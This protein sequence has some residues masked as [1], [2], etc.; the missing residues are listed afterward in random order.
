MHWYH[1]RVVR[2]ETWHLWTQ[3]RTPQALPGGAIAS[4]E[5]YKVKGRVLN[6]QN[7]RQSRRIAGLKGTFTLSLLIWRQNGCMNGIYKHFWVY[8]CLKQWPALPSAGVATV[9]ANVSLGIWVAYVYKRVYAHVKQGIDNMTWVTSFF[10]NLV[11]PQWK[12]FLRRKYPKLFYW[13]VSLSQSSAW[14]DSM[15]LCL[16]QWFLYL[17]QIFFCSDT[18]SVVMSTV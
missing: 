8:A 9:F 15:Y 7:Q 11:K 10:F 1:C 16:Q 17:W 2:N 12:A 3:P 18:R 6:E 5:V 14:K 13:N 4:W